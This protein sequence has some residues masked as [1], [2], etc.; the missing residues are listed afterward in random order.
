M[1]FMPDFLVHTSDSEPGIVRRVRGRGFS[2]HHPDGSLVEDMPTLERIKLLGLPPAWRDVWVC[3]N[4][5]GHLQATGRDDAERKQYRYHERW[6]EHRDR[7][8]YAGLVE[9]GEALPALRARVY[10]DLQRNR[11]DKP[12]VSAALVRLLDRT[13]LRVGNTEYAEENGS[14]GATTLRRKHVKLKGDQIRLD[15]RAKGGKRV[16]RQVGDRTLHRVLEQIEELPGYEL[17]HYLDDDGDVRRLD[18][19]DVNEYLAQTLD[20]EFTAKTFRTWRGTVEAFA[21]ACETPDLTI[22]GMCQRAAEAL[23]NTPAICRK[24]YVHPDVIALAEMDT[25]KRQEILAGPKEERCDGLRKAEAGLL[26]FLS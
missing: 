16:R 4:P 9:F 3:A 22:K 25:E 17:F 18:S 20:G 21:E 19:A 11:A 23:H 7:L 5:H 6:R 1:S 10:R 15:F 26:A 24:S 14:F 8:K 13:A 2:F 12:F